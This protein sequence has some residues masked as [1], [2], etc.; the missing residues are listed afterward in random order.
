MIVY[1]IQDAKNFLRTITLKR[2]WNGL[3]VLSSF[4]LSRLI[5]KPVHWG[6]PMSI[7]IEPTN[8]CNLGCTECPTGLKILTRRNGNLSMP[9]FQKTIDQ[10]YKFTS[11]LTLYFQGEPFMNPAFF[12]FVAYASKK[13]MYTTTSTNGHYFTEANCKKAVD[14]GLSR[15]I[16]SVDGTTQDV[17]EKYRKDG[18]LAKV[19]EG[20]EMMMRTKKELKAKNP[21]VL[22]QFIVF[23]DN[24]HQIEDIQKLAKDIGVDH[25][26][27][28]TAQVYDFENS[29]NIIPDNV[30]YS[31]Y[32]KRKDGSYE[33]KNKYYNHCWRSWQSSVITW[34][35]H[36]VPCCFDK[37]ATY[38]V[39]DLK[40]ESFKD[41]WESEDLKLFRGS[42]LTNRKQID[43]CQNCVE[44]TKIWI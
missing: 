21:L 11:Y 38:K 44:G 41:V 35:G 19:I 15:L 3:K 7:S 18:N 27:L 31:R 24:E 12:E 39:G 20:L 43:I 14:S 22:L 8:L 37:D 2:I 1:K 32:K 4:Y 28:K 13:K 25:L 36:M 29:K 6:M 16:V 17:Y 10:I 9:L 30:K 5:R 23:K 26:A 34:D 33:I 40:S 42:I